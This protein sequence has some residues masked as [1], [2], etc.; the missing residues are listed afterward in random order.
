MTDEKILT[1]LDKSEFFEIGIKTDYVKLPN[2]KRM[3]IQELS[4]DQRVDFAK[5]NAD[6]QGR[7]RISDN[8]KDS[9]A[10]VVI[11][12]AIAEDGDPLFTDDDRQA[13]REGSGSIVDMVATAILN[14]SGMGAGAVEAAAKN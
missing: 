1:V 12:G 9:I 6:G 8:S 13:L 10:K 7:M 11:W 14:L 2:G 3:K 4:S 5:D